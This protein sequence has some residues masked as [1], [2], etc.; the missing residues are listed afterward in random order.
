VIAGKTPGRSY[1]EREEPAVPDDLDVCR[2]HAGG[3]IPRCRAVEP[4]PRSSHFCRIGPP[5]PVASAL[6]RDEA[7]AREPLPGTSWFGVLAETRTSTTAA[8][9]PGPRGTSSPPLRASWLVA[10]LAALPFGQLVRCISFS[11]NV[12][13]AV[14]RRQDGPAL[15]GTASGLRKRVVGAYALSWVAG[16]GPV[17]PHTEVATMHDST[18]ETVSVGLDVHKS[19][20][21]VAG[22]TGEMHSIAG[23]FGRWFRVLPRIPIAT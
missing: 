7:V 11:S 17:E 4:Q 18:T 15:G 1:A 5:A 14:W 6:G 23:R 2:R 12:G 22:G 19:S 20:V 9:R 16:V 8:P 21:R 3:N 13:G 10:R